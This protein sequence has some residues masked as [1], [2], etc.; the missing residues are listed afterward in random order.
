MELL[1]KSSP[2]FEVSK[3]AS[4]YYVF[5]GFIDSKQV[6]VND[7]MWLHEKVDAGNTQ[8]FWQLK[9]GVNLKKIHFSDTSKYAI[10]YVYRPGKVSNSL[11]QYNVYINEVPLCVA[12]NNTGY[13]FAIIKEGK[14]EIKSKL[15]KD[16][17]TAVIDV[18]FGN[19][20]YVKSM[21]HWGISSRLYNFKL[22]MAAIKPADG[23]TEFAEV[24]QK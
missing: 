4:D 21:I 23:K 14:Y 8:L 3:V 16:V 9:P 10:L 11:A 19:V 2:E 5:D 12:Q 20:Y 24:D 1:K 22:E 15:Y 6:I 17:A 18:K 13:G 7:T